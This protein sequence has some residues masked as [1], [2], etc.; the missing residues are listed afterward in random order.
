MIFENIKELAEKKG[1]TIAELERT[2]GFQNGTIGKWKNH[3]PLVAN[4]EKV[5]KVLGVPVS[6]LL[7]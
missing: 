3:S 4:L 2:A 1:F 5:A 6:R 7:K